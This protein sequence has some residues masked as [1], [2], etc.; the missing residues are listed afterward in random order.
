MSD[1]KKGASC[2]LKAFSY[3]RD[4]LP[5]KILFWVRSQSEERIV[6]GSISLIPLLEEEEEEATGKNNEP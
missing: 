1:G 5:A 6:I 3:L 4:D 2:S